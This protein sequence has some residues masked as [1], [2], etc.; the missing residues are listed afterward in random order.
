MAVT[1]G[2]TLR[3]VVY[4]IL[5]DLKQIYKDAEITPFKVAYWV[6]V[7]ADRLK[8]LHIEKRDSGAYVVPSFAISV[9]VDSTNGRNYFEIPGNLYDFDKDRAVEYIT[10]PPGFDSDNPM[11]AGVVFTRVNIAEIRRLYYRDEERPSAVNPYFYRLQDRIYLLGVEQINLTF[12]EAGLMMTF[13]PSATDLTLDQVFDFPQD[14]IPILKRQILDMGRFAMMVPED[15]KDDGAS[16][17]AREMP[18]DKLLSVND[19]VNPDVN[20]N[21]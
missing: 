9:S 8:K 11:F 3:Y 18:K 2:A 14:L 6:L 10:Y 5:G 4:D 7:H 12:V 13:S 15:L 16:L 20:N 17:Q 21:R 1:G 19:Q